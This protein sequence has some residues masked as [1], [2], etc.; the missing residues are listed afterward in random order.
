MKDALEPWPKVLTRLGLSCIGA[1]ED[2]LLYAHTSS[3]CRLEVHFRAWR[4]PTTVRVVVRPKQSTSTFLLAPSDKVPTTPQWRTGDPEFDSV[5]AIVAGGRSVLHRLSAKMRGRL[6]HLVGELGATVGGAEST[7]E[8]ALTAELTDD[9]QVMDAIAALTEVTV[10]LARDSSVEDLI[11]R[12]LHQDGAP[13]V[14]VAVSRRVLEL[15]PDLTEAQA[16]L[17]CRYLVE[18][19]EEPPVSLVATMPPFP[20]VL[21][22]W[23]RVGDP[24]DPRIAERVVEAWQRGSARPAARYVGRLMVRMEELTDARSVVESLWRTPGLVDDPDFA[25]ELVRTVRHAPPEAARPLVQQLVPRSSSVARRLG[26]VLAGYAH[27]DTDSRLVQW[28]RLPGSGVRR[29][30]GEALAVRAKEELEAGRPERLAPD[31]RGVPAT[32]EP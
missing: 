1:I 28:L 32:P 18:R 22:T 24:L 15:L 8:P 21:R 23:F 9:T 6:L 10:A 4:T 12:W 11:E 14:E 5:V 20:V 17:A 2:G 26:R 25:R 30:A 27:P 7:L 19:T 16:E 13:G 31:R 29:A 3:S